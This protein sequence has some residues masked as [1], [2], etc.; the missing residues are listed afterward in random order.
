MGAKPRRGVRPLLREG[1]RVIVM[2][3]AG[4]A[5]FEVHLT[6]RAI[7]ALRIEEGKEVWLAIKTYSCN[8][9]EPAVQ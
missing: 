3:D 1:V 7:G 5:T 8:L 4:G 2:I 6:P 9:V